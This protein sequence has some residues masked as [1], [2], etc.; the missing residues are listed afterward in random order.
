MRNRVK[1]MLGGGWKLLHQQQVCCRSRREQWERGRQQSY[2]PV[3]AV[4]VCGQGQWGE[5]SCVSWPVTSPSIH[6]SKDEKTQGLSGG[7]LVFCRE[8]CAGRNLS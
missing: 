3:A 6:S 8:G 4:H 5:D 1:K 7:H 2:A